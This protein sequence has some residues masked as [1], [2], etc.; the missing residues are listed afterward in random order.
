MEAGIQPDTVLV[1][2]TILV[3]LALPSVVAALSDGRAPRVAAVLGLGGIG[4]LWWAV[5]R[6]PGPFALR[7]VPDAFITVVARLI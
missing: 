5:A 6:W 7:D 1:L 4:C 3:W 2:G